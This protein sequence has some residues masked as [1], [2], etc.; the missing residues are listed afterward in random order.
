[1]KAF[2][3]IAGLLVAAFCALAPAP[4]SAQAGR[5]SVYA[6]S[7]V[8]VDATAASSAEAQTQAFA[9]GQA[10]ALDRLIRRLTL[11][12]DLARLGPP[13]PDRAT[14]E[15]MASSIDVDE[16]RRSGTRYIGRLSVRF[17]PSAVQS[18]L[19]GAGFA[20]VDSRGPGV[21][22]VPLW[23]NVT[24]DA[25]DSWRA[26]WEQGGYG[27]E[28][29]PLRIA[30]RALV[31]ATDWNMAASYAQAAGAATALYLDLRVAGQTATA[32]M[33][34]VGPGMAPRDRGMVQAQVGP[35]PEG[36]AIAMQGLADSVSERLQ[37]E[38]KVRVATTSGQRARVSASALFESQAEWQRIKGGLERAASALIS[39]IRIEAVARQGALISFS[40]VGSRE[41][42][43][44][45][46][47]RLG[48]SMEETAQGPVLRAVN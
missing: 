31:G 2:A 29:V 6:V 5:E 10:L 34:E 19:R 37:T 9:T 7:G 35:G 46:L 23:T 47:R 17:Q 40:F 18:L 15:R 33:V 48:V 30:P 32:R 27:E 13:R 21:L 12:D 14:I 20:I 42:L 38:W 39:E 26:A 16:E 36:L 1:M 3:G 22:V 24:Q 25:A 4:A 44:A 45:E 41:Q 8:R 43:A 11:P 28:L